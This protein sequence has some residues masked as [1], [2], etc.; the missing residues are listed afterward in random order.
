MRRELLR[1]AEEVGG[2][3][4]KRGFA[5]RTIGIKIRFADFRTITRVRT[6]PDAGPTGR[7]ST[8]PR[9]SSTGGLDL[10]QPRIRLVGVKCEGLRTAADVAEQLTL[11]LDLAGAGAGATA[12]GA[13]RAARDN[14]V[15][16]GGRR[17]APLRAAFR[18]A[19]RLAARPA[20]RRRPA[21]DAPTADPRR[22]RHSES[23]ADA[24]APP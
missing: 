23:R 3:V 14:A 10:D 21:A 17:Q 11:D 19:A 18:T 6:L 24:C 22:P 15:G 8:T 2:R 5:A 1:L 16:G 13:R 7:E 4:R 20:P 12:R 9:S